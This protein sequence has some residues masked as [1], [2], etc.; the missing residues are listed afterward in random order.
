MVEYSGI[1]WLCVCVH[2]SMCVCLCDGGG[3]EV[4]QEWWLFKI[5]ARME[6]KLCGSSGGSGYIRALLLPS[7]RNSTAEKCCS[8]SQERSNN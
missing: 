2:V 7:Q 1:F 8:R 4:L 5:V 6:A 3:G